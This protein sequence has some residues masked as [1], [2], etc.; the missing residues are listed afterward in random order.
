[1]QHPHTTRGK[2][3]ER[4]QARERR[5]LRA[6]RLFVQSVP[7]AEIARRLGVS[8]AAVCQWHA[9]WE[10]DGTD[11]LKSRGLGG[12]V[13]RL[14]TNAQKEVGHLLRKPASSFG[15]TTDFWT[16][17][18]IAAVIRRETGVRYHPGHVWKLL[19]RELGFSWQKPETR[20]RER[21]EREI[22]RW[23]RE[24]WPRI[25]KGGIA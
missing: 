19:R 10:A 8:R 16:L 15:Y 3:R 2:G 17:E 18:R 5:R 7:Q 23:V 11:G 24:D 4:Q 22:R 21:N 9:A 25:K 13:P 1:M 12:P 6:G 20:A 14:T